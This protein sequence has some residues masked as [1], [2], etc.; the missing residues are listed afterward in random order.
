LAVA[1]DKQALQ[2][3]YLTAGALLGML[4]VIFGALGAHALKEK[5]L[6]AQLS[7]FETAV[8]FQFFHALLFLILGNSQVLLQALRAKTIFRLLLWGVLLFSGSI[9]VLATKEI[10]GFNN[11]R[12]LGPVTPLGGVLMIS[13]W[14][15]LSISFY[16]PHKKQ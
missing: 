12:W 4:A 5:L 2:R 11:L 1:E 10:S 8:K 16:Q 14:A 13:G 3:N 15:L 9:Y 7:S 6:P